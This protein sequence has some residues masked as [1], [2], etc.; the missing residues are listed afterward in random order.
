MSTPFVLYSLVQYQTPEVRM[1]GL[2]NLFD[3]YVCPWLLKMQLF[4]SFGASLIT[5]RSSGFDPIGM[6]I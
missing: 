3:T 2:F 1:T 6:L 5:A 4:E